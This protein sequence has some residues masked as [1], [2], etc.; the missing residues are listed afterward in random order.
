V[1]SVTIVSALVVVVEIG[2]S[3]T[4][5]FMMNWTRERVTSR[6]RRAFSS[7]SAI[8]VTVTDDTL[9]PASLAKTVLIFFI[10]DTEISS[11]GSGIRTVITICT[12]LSG[13]VG[14]GVVVD[15]AGVVVVGML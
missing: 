10:T 12:D 4:G 13:V 7:Y 14:G 8:I 1:S 5:I 15:M 3:T 9:T 2:S 11:F 6:R